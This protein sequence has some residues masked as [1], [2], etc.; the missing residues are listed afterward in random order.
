MWVFSRINFGKRTLKYRNKIPIPYRGN[1]DSQ[2]MPQIH[3]VLSVIKHKLCKKLIYLIT[4]FC[5]KELENT[6]NRTVN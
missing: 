1:M 4:F 6:S 2:K 3:L 5:N